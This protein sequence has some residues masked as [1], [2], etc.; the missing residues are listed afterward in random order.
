MNAVVD[1]ARADGFAQLAWWVAS[2]DDMLRRFVLDA[3]WVADGAHRTVGTP[4]GKLGPRSAAAIRQFQKDRG[5]AI[6]GQLDRNT[7]DALS[8]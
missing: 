4:D 2:Q 7:L 8:R 3:G 6:N 1:T 5:L